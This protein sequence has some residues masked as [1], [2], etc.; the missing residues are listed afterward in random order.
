[1]YHCFFSSHPEY[2]I[3][4]YRYNIFRYILK[5]E[6][7]QIKNEIIKEVMHEYDRRN[8]KFEIKY[9]N[10]SLYVFVRDI[11]YIESRRK[12]IIL[13]T[14]NNEEFAF[15]KQINEMEQEMAAHGFARCHKSYIVNLNCVKSINEN[16]YLRLKS[17]EDI[18]IGRKYYSE[19]RQALALGRF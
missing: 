19:I 16:K 1:M 10:R 5:S 3:K 7:E 4:G 14:V 9:K 13:H 12:E 8:A 11:E 6:P 18:P 15:F 2:A 17:G